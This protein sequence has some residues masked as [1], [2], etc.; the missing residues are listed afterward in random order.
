MRTTRWSRGFTLI[1]LLVVI[2]IIAILA[3]ILFPVFAQAR[4][5]ARAASCLS[6]MKQIMT[7]VKMYTQDYD[8][9]HMSYLW[10]PVGGGNYVTWMEL[11]NPYVKN[12]QVFIC[13]SG[14]KYSGTAGYGGCSFANTITSHYCW[15]GWFAYDYW[16]WTVTNPNGAQSQTVMF[17]GVPAAP[18][19]TKDPNRP[20]Q[21]IRSI[22]FAEYPAESAFLIEGYM[23][24]LYP[25]STN[26]FGYP[27]TTGFGSLNGTIDLRDRNAFRHNGGMTVGYCDGHAKL[28]QGTRFW[29]DNSA[30][31]H[32]AG[33]AYPQGAHMRV[34][35]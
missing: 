7:G 8:E 2:A 3:A 18:V 14:P 28:V 4:E 25:Y 10:T 13:P 32:Y 1:E 9:Q 20:W 6:N 33:G 27:C 21:E 12:T 11:V 16:G 24:S 22:E 26:A 23:S 15:M 30:Q 34:G 5:K 17:S 29:Q 35:P 19:L 31:A